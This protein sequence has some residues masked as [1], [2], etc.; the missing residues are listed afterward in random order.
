MNPIGLVTVVER[1]KRDR[2]DR[3]FRARPL[4]CMTLSGTFL[5]LKE[6]H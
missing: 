4:I 6:E 2:T 5:N 1:L 3:S